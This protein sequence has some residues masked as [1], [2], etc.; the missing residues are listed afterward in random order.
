MP[1]R[2]VTGLNR[3][4]WRDKS[5]MR[6]TSSAAIRFS[7]ART[8][9][10]FV[11]IGN[12]LGYQLQL[13]GGYVF[14]EHAA[15]AIEDETAVGR[16]GLNADSIALRLFGELFVLDDLQLHQTAD[17]DGQQQQPD[18]GRQ[19]HAPEKTTAVRSDGP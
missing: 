5:T 2:S 3:G 7:S 6:G 13:I 10:G 12:L 17:D 4:P 8:R 1:N 16:Y 11:Q 14:R 18:D 15:F 19:S 9:Q